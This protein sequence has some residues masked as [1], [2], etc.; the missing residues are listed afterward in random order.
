MIDYFNHHV[1]GFGLILRLHGSAAAKAILPS[2]LSVAIYFLINWK[3]GDKDFS[4]NEEL[5]FID[6]TYVVGAVIACFTF[7][8][9]FRANFSYGRVGISF[10]ILSTIS[11]N[12]HS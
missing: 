6:H 12:S 4:S 7:L 8:L 9:V 11:G 3:F 1:L 2:T 5:D 10:G